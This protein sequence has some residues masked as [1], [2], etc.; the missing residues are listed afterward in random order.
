MKQSTRIISP[1]TIVDN[2]FSKVGLGQITKTDPLIMSKLIKE[3]HLDNL[4]TSYP[5]LQDML[6]AAPIK[7]IDLT[8]FLQQTKHGLSNNLIVCDFLDEASS[9]GFLSPHKDYIKALHFAYILEQVT[10]AQANSLTASKEI[11]QHY[12]NER[13]KNGVDTLHPLSAVLK[14]AKLTRSPF[15]TAKM[16]SVSPFM[17]KFLLE[18]ENGGPIGTRR[19]NELKKSGSISPLENILIKPHHFPE[20]MNHA[21]IQLNILEAGTEEYL[22]G[23]KNNAF[24]AYALKKGCQLK[25]KIEYPK[26]SVFPLSH[27]EN[28]KPAQSKTSQKLN[29]DNVHP[30]YEFSKAWVDLYESWNMSFVVSDLHDLH[31]I[32]PKLFIPSQIDAKPK[33]FIFNRGLSLDT[34]INFYLFRVFDNI[35]HVKQPE[36]SREIAQLWGAINKQHCMRYIKK[37]LKMDPKVFEKEFEAHCKKGLQNFAS[38]TKDFLTM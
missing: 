26:G 34:A 28:L 31:L 38:L 30:E 20:S 25:E 27:I 29:S 9:S 11:Q 17:K 18:R 7:P 21:A 24:V 35:E 33:D 8:D 15:K 5:P 6:K 4:K 36:K 1:E 16:I 12:Y 32:L 2:A 23:F 3:M 22:R 19:A 37:E 13:L 14:V 10:L